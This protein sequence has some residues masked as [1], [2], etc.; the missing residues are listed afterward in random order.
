MKK[1]FTS[2][3]LILGIISLYAQHSLQSELN[4]FRAG[5]EIIKQQV[6]YK[7]PGRTGENVLWDFS[8]LTSVDDAM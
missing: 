7:D 5:D 4:Y 2:I 1:A 8:R 6:V 3:M